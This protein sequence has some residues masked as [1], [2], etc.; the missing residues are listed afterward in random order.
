MRLADLPR[1]FPPDLFAVCA[2]KA[3]PEIMAHI[4]NKDSCGLKAWLTA[5]PSDS[6][7]EVIVAWR[8]CPRTCLTVLV[9]CTM[10]VV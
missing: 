2:D 6:H 4:L 9:G 10:R 7:P 1:Y 8:S 5:V 3:E